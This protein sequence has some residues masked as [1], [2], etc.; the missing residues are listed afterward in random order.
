MGM[1]MRKPFHK[2]ITEHSENGNA[3]L[4]CHLPGVSFL[5]WSVPGISALNWLTEFTSCSADSTLYGEQRELR[6][7]SVSVPKCAS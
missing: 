3:V 5:I 1:L 4:R 7:E 6:S 2:M